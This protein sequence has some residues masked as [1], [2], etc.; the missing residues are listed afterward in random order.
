MKKLFTEEEYEVAK[1]KDCLTLKCYECDSSFCK[2]K[3]EVKN[4]LKPN[5]KNKLK[6][7][8]KKCLHKNKNLKKE[9]ECKLCKKR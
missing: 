3:S 2:T 4:A 7:C 6:F 5:S 9:I 8:S 1:G